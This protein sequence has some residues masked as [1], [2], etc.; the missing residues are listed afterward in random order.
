[1]MMLGAFVGTFPGAPVDGVAVAHIGR[2]WAEA[3]A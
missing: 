3:K 1:M 2:T